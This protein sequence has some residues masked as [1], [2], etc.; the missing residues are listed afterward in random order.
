MKIKKLMISCADDQ[1]TPINIKV[2]VRIFETGF[3]CFQ[4]YDKII[5]IRNLNSCSQFCGIISMTSIARENL[6][7]LKSYK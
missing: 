5:Y 7:N 6:K 3:Q 4:L 2:K 1:L